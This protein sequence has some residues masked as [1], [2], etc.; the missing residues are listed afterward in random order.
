MPR[1]GNV[2]V[3]HQQFSRVALVVDDEAHVLAKVSGWLAKTS[4]K[5]VCVRTLSEAVSVSKDPTL[6][7]ALVDYRLDTGDDGIRL[8][9]ILRRRRGL[10]FVLFSGYLT[11]DLTV[12]AMRAGATDVIEKPLDEERLQVVVNAASRPKDWFPADDG[13]T[14]AQ[15]RV[16]EL[17]ADGLGSPTTRWAHMV[18]R[19]CHARADPH[20]VL[21][22]AAFLTRGDWTVRECCRLCH[23]SAN[24]SCDLARFL[25]AIA[26]SRTT[27]QPLENHFAFGDQR[28][29]GHL[30]KKAG[31]VRGIRTVAL[32]D[33]L[34]KQ[35]FIPT[36]KPCLREL[37][38]LAANSPFF[39]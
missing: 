22:W 31:L 36:W 24:D 37:A 15:H 7:I 29:L 17:A 9:R 10:P 16:D 34:V 6:T 4:W 38:H 27:L 21:S 14:A 12:A 19:T 32:K 20:S 18:L 28:T 39:F 35:T 25:R 26:R 11:I 5:C 30:F 2:V 23:V 33:F 3:S 1:S 13:G 8:G